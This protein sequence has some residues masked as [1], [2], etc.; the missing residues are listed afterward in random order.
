MPPLKCPNEACTF[1]FDPSKVP[2]GAVLACPRCGTRF[3][4]GQSVAAPQLGLQPSTPQ[5]KPRKSRGF[6]SYFLPALAVLLVIGGFF[7]V[8][9]L[10]GGKSTNNP[11]HDIKS[12]SLNFSFTPPGGEWQPDE[13]MKSN[14]LGVNVA[15]FRRTLPDA[16]VALA[17]K[18]FEG[19]TPRQ[20]ELESFLD[21]RLRRVFDNLSKEEK[22]GAIWTGK[23]ALRIE[24]RATAKSTE[25]VFVGECYALVHKGVGYWFFAWATPHDIAKVHEEFDTIRERLTLLNGRDNWKE[26]VPNKNVLAGTAGYTLTDI[27]GIWTKPAQTEPKDEDPK[28]DLLAE[29]ID[30]VK[31]QRSDGKPT[32]N[33]VAFLLDSTGDPLTAARKYVEAR[34]NRDPETFGPA[35]IEELSDHPQGDPPAGESIGE[36]K[37]VRLKLTRPNSPSSAKLLVVAGVEVGGKVVAVEL[38]C[39][40]SQRQVWEKRL[41]ALAASL[42]TGQ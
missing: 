12:E 9:T 25:A 23:P 17:A 3:S 19:R 6:R 27:E 40:L 11:S 13:E 18:D 2:A 7:G 29:A 33:L 10:W 32:A 37:S 16:W 1:L 35:T 24:F 20:S 8:S 30:V 31:G 21:D 26:T 22:T 42:S 39:P 34:Y 4:L 41:L 36:T 28:A 5:E 14:R 15:A 38:S